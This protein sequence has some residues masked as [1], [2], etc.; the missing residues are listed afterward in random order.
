[1]ITPV[2]TLW[3]LR[4]VSSAARVGE[5]SAVV[6]KLLKRR[7]AL[8]IR[9]MVGVGIGPPKVLLAP[10]P[11]SSVRMM[12]MFGAPFGRRHRLGEVLYGI[13]GR[14]PDL[15]FENRIGNR[16]VAA[17]LSDSVG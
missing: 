12:R 5:Q 15:A 10:K 6:W 11:T 16:Q 17:I 4:P 2:A 1:M 8:A 9:S 14:Q 7:P 3:W 13:G